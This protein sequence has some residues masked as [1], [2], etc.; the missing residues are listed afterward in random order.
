MERGYFS[1]TL[2]F[3]Q[4]TEDDGLHPKLQW[5]Y[6]CKQSPQTCRCYVAV[7]RLHHGSGSPAV[8]TRLSVNNTTCVNFC[9]LSPYVYFTSIILMI[10]ANFLL[11][12]SK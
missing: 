6:L 8:D 4:G 5:L 7:C 1:E 12:C 9:H 11:L 2:S 10:I 3:E